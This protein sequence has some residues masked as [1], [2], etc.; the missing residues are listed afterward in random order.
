[1]VKMVRN[2][3]GTGAKVKEE[4]LREAASIHI[5][6]GQVQRYC[7]LMVEI[8]EVRIWDNHKRL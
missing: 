2:T 1:M 5:R 6:L 4:K 8:H 3:S 7:E